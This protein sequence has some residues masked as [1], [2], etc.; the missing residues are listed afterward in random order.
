MSPVRALRA[1]IRGMLAR[2]LHV[3]EIPVAL[4]HVRTLGFSPRHI[5]DVG[6]YQGE[7]TRLCR[8]LWPKAHIHAFEPQTVPGLEESPNVSIHRCLLGAANAE[9]VPLRAAA[10]AA[11][12]LEEYVH[13]EIT[14]RH[15]MRTLDETI[16]AA[17]FIKLDVQ[18][19]ELEVLRGAQRC[20]AGAKLLLAEM[21]LLD[22]HQGVPLLAEVV[23]W[24]DA[25]GWVAYDV[26]G[27]TRR[28]LDGALWQADMLFVPRESPLRADKRWGVAG[29]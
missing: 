29:P 11:S 14:G 17:D 7:F 5:A 23:A 9:E 16:P 18:G 22:I 28:P 20:L 4:A 24:L 15:P 12:V 8:E 3:P 13:H 2:R 1:T 25:R 19:Y 26:C 27:L 10:T 21:N 6:A